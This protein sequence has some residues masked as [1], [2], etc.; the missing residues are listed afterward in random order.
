[1]HIF[2]TPDILQTYELPADE[3]LHCAKVLRMVEGESVLLV[4]GMGTFYR[5]ELQLVHPKRCKVK[6]LESFTDD[7]KR[8]Y[9]VHIAMAP[10]K[11]MDRIEWFAEKATE[12]G[13][14]GIHFLKCR[15]S[16]RKEIKV[17]RIQKIVVSAMKQSQKASLPLL[18]D[19]I[20]FTSF[21]KKPFDGQKFIAHCYAD[22]PRNEFSTNYTKG[23]N[24][25]ILIG[26]EGDFSEA[27]VSLAIENGF[28]A[29]S[30]GKSRLRT[31]TAALVACHTP[32]LINGI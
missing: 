32:H 13:I 10:T 12:I 3:S 14:D 29:V 11:N 31:E 15:Y 6:I 23:Q 25:L 20:D 17:E 5:A 7:T 30:L 1:M 28:V 4:D 8:D 27:E 26:P 18:Q 21:V 19:M 24:V 16:E 2:Y 9:Q 22:Q